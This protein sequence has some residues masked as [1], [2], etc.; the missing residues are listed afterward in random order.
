MKE[1][2]CE[3]IILKQIGSKKPLVYIKRIPT[4]ST[5]LFYLSPNLAKSSCKQSLPFV[6]VAPP[7]CF[8][9]TM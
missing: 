3:I 8:G 5:S 1:K 9:A 2:K 7:P 6:L 4:F